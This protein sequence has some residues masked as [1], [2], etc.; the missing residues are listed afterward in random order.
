MGAGQQQDQERGSS[1][2]AARQG[3]KGEWRL[4]WV[5]KGAT[6]GQVK[7]I[8]ITQIEGFCRLFLYAFFPLIFIFA[9]IL[10]SRYYHSHF[11]DEQ[12]EASRV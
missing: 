1:V 9:T 3:Y 12:T 7:L 4:T 11:T 2:R 5:R 8:I 6:A 10:G